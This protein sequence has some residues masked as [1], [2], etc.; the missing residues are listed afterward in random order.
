MQSYRVVRRRQDLE[1]KI[2]ALHRQEQLAIGILDMADISDLENT[3]RWYLENMNFSLHVM[4][5]AAVAEENGL[6]EKY[7]DVNFILF[8]SAVT[9]GEA[10]N[11]FSNECYTTLFL[12]VRSD[13]EMIAYSGEALIKMMSEKNHPAVITPVLISSQGD[14]IPTLRSPHLRGKDFDPVS[15]KPSLDENVWDMNL[16]PVLG[17]GLYD[18]ALFQRLRAFDEDI[19]G[20]FYQ[21]ADY[22]VRVYL[23]GYSISSSVNLAF[24]FPRRM[25][26]IEDRSECSGINRFYTKNFSI[27]RIA[28]KNVVEKWK[29]YV[30]KGILNDE[31]KKKLLVLQKTDIFSLIES[32]P[33]KED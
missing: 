4:T 32:W 17:L 16:Y 31:V 8:K 25:S 20:E 2:S 5:T 27:H 29:P 14:V 10:I 13:T 24:R 3:I 18:R 9:T 11:A 15:L 19:S 26:I 6:T 28:G 12:V 7:Q 21:M 33:V 1:M 22:G 30:D 23:M